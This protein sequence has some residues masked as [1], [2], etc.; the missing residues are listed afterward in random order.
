[1]SH[2]LHKQKN[3]FDLIFSLLNKN[4][5]RSKNAIFF[6]FIVYSIV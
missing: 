6:M 1:M 5:I 2:F 3:Q 4:I